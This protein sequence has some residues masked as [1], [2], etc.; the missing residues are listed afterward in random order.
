MI[1]RL[2]LIGF[3]SVGQEFA[4]LLIRKRDWLLREKGL[5]IEVLAIATKT[6]GSLISKKAL[7]IEHVLDHRGANG[8]LSDFGPESTN[9]TPL[10]I[11]DKTD[12]DLMIEL[13]PLNIDSGQPAI[14]HIKAAFG[15][16][17]D[18]VT[19]NKGPIA[20][21]Y[22]ELRALARSKG[23]HFRFEGTVM[24][25]TPVFNLVERTLPGCQVLGIEGILNSTTNFV[26]TEMSKG[27]S[28]EDAIKQAQAGGFAESD[29]SLDVDGWDAAAK[30][31][32]LANVLMDADS[33]PKQVHRQGIRNVSETDMK[34]AKTDGL[35]IKQIA[36][37]TRD[38]DGVDLQVKPEL[39]DS[40]SPFWSIDGTSSALRLRTD[41]MGDIV[42]SEINP[43]VAQTAYAVLSD[44]LLITESIRCGTL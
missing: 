37:A 7:D 33:N 31:A 5:D 41:L 21:A 15:V 3:G 28:M 19:A 34:K 26:L 24:D 44:I 22:R 39:V 16:G 29:A 11:I 17:L 25:G 9:L 35:K 36:I 12:A 20:Y 6:R 27:R 13:T 4:H 18:V 14:D 10:Q 40:S 1:L 38:R 30:I 42:V 2:A 43:N 23:V 8:T 32:A